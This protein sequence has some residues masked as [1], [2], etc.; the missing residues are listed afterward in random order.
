MK[1]RVKSGFAMAPLLLVVYWSGA[2]LYVACFVLSLLAVREFYGVFGAD[3]AASPAAGGGFV[4]RRAKPIR[5]IAYAGAAFLY[6]ALFLADPL[7]VPIGS[8]LALWAFLTV[9]LS[10]VCLFRTGKYT[11]ADAMITM[12][13]VFYVIFFLF[14][15]ALI[16]YFFPVGSAGNTWIRFENPLWLVI[17]A[18]FGSDIF[19][20]FAG[21]LMGKHRLCPNI[22]PKKTVEGAIGGVVGSAALCGAFGDFAVPGFVVNSII[23][24]VLGGLVSQAGDLAA[25]VIKRQTGVKDYGNLIP[26]HGGVLDRIDSVL[27]TAPT[28]FYYI[29]FAQCPGISQM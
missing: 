25:S 6:G 18:A 12:T 22:S 9:A 3:S 27:F 7:D 2:L 17:F 13:G 19:A 20:Y 10:L 28:V 4:S 11:L 29:Y 8:V 15:A 26:G 23:V 21:S 5:W 16:V 24:G 1:T 14:H